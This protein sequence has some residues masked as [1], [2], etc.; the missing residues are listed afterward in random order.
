MPTTAQVIDISAKTASPNATN[1]F[2]TLVDVTRC[3]HEDSEQ[4]TATSIAT[5]MRRNK[6]AVPAKKVDGGSSSDA[7]HATSSRLSSQDATLSVV[8]NVNGGSSNARL[9]RREQHEQRRHQSTIR[10]CH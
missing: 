9:V 4:P 6:D 2:P 8:S 3:L 5:S 1:T 7:L 10:S